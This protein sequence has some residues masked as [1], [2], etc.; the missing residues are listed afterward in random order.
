MNKVFLWTESRNWWYDED[1]KIH[2]QD[3][4]NVKIHSLHKP[5]VV[6]GLVAVEILDEDF[7]STGQI[8][9]VYPDQLLTLAE[10]PVR[11]RDLD[12]IVHPQDQDQDQ[13]TVPIL[14]FDAPPVVGFPAFAGVI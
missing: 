1:D 6:N 2:Y 14:R 8:N 10:Q 9:F 12:R 13:D 4:V 5:L 7:N 3:P 11:Q